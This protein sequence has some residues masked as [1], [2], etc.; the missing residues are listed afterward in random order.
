MYDYFDFD[1]ASCDSSTPTTGWEF[2]HA[3]TASKA[4]P[5]QKFY[6]SMLNRLVIDSRNREAHH[7]TY[8][9]KVDVA[10]IYAAAYHDP[11]LGLPP[12]TQYAFLESPEAYDSSDSE[13]CCCGVDDVGI[14]SDLDVHFTSS[15]N[16]FPPTSPALVAP[17]ELPTKCQS[18]GD[19]VTDRRGSV[20][21]PPGPRPSFRCAAT[22]QPH[23]IVGGLETIVQSP[24]KLEEEDFQSPQSSAAFYSG[25]SDQ[26]QLIHLDFDELTVGVSTASAGSDP[27]ESREA[28]FPAHSSVA[29]SHSLA[30]RTMFSTTNYSMKATASQRSS[31]KRARTA[32]GAWAASQSCRGRILGA[33]T[34]TLAHTTQNTLRTAAYGI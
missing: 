33:G 34:S 13:S 25:R 3:Q 20:F 9:I 5:P 4:T 23:D 7:D 24:P 26:L 10:G 19:H 30:K 29:A 15:H 32:T 21:D 31:E 18:R 8:Q 12:F 2:L 17:T 1:A 27:G 28:E 11:S 14:L 16:P 22:K 6:E